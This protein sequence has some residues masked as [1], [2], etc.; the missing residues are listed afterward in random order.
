MQR[1]PVSPLEMTPFSLHTT[2]TP[3][4]EG[5]R[6]EPAATKKTKGALIL[7]GRSGC[8]HTQAPVDADTRLYKT[9][10]LLK[11]RKR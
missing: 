6:P 5:T 1:A 9:D 3:R 4:N 2:S 10:T 7:A 8:K 11:D